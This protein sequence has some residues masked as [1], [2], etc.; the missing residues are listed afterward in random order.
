MLIPDNR[1]FMKPPLLNPEIYHKVNDSATSRDKGA[2]WK[3]RLLVKSTIALIKA[4]V[5]L[6]G[7][8]HYPQNKIPS[9]LKRKLQDVSPLLH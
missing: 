8:E 3:Q 2:Q 5:S 6:K 7:Q 1:L 4:V 9:D